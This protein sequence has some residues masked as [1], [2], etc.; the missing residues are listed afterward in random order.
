MRVQSMSLEIVPFRAEHLI[1]MSIEVNELIAKRAV[2]IEKNPGPKY[3]ALL[4]GKC[5]GSGGALW[6]HGRVFMCWLNPTTEL[7]KRPIA[8]HRLAKRLFEEFKAKYNWQRIEAL[9]VSDQ[10]KNLKWAHSFGF[11]FKGAP[12]EKAGPFGEDVYRLAIVR[13]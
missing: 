10:P 4:D 8:F 5:I 2:M 3:S 13:R 7:T 6:I 1:D 12:E 11:E 9:C